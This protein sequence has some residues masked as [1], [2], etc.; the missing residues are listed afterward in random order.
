[1]KTLLKTLFFATLIGV[2]AG[3]SDTSEI[4][5][6]E[7]LS[8]KKGHMEPGMVTVPFKADLVGEYQAYYFPG[9]DKFICSDEFGC[10]IIVD[11]EGTATHMG[12]VSAHF[13]F[14]AC[15]PPN[16][17]IENVSDKY[18]PAEV[19]L[20]AANGDKL[21]LMVEG[22]VVT[23][24]LDYHPEDVWSYWKDEYII[25]GGTGRFDGATGT[26]MTDDYNRTSYPESS[27]HH[28]SGTINMKK[29]R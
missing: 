1:M 17:D 18:G 11:A 22:Y 23:G 27:F 13:D 15:G 25:T 21:F 10:Q 2:I 28:W 7:N 26:L 20:I 19:S 9:M 24:N 5:S 6:L 8:L 4:D 12:K 14:C 16:P 3:C 29:G